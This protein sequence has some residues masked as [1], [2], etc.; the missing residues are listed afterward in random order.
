MEGGREEVRCWDS[1]QATQNM[2]QWQNNN[3]DLKLLKKRPMQEGHSEPPVSLKKGNQYP[4]WKV[5]S[6]PLE[7]GH[8]YHPETGNLGL[9]SL[10]KQTSL[11]L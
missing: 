4:M 10:C 3:F 8:P 6:L 7:V 11:H 1:G 2:T 5:P 9:R